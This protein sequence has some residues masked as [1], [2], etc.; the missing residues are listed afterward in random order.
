MP[1]TQTSEEESLGTLVAQATSQ[2]SDLVRAEI[3]L[4]KSELSF[5]AKRVGI[6]VGMFAAAAFTAHLVLILLS[7][8][9]GYV[10][11]I[12]LPLPAAFGIV[13]AFYIL[14]AGLMVL[15]GRSRLRGLTKMKRTSDSLRGL[16][17]LAT[18]EPDD[19]P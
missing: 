17:D 15:F 19:G 7:F 3:E 13:T 6:A 5:D 16:K 12:W 11:A 2:I 9:I 8:T 4:A 1:E 14:M 10:L 18:P